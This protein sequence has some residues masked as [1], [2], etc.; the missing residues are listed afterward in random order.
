[1][2]IDNI[3]RNNTIDEWRIQTNQSA[4]ALNTI[5][6]GNF[7]KSN[8]SLTI[9]SN[10]SLVITANGTALQVSNTVLFQTRLEVGNV[11]SLGVR[12]SGTGNLTVGNTVSILGANTAL[13]VANNATVNT[14]LTVGRNIL[15]PNTGNVIFAN[16]GS[17]N[18]QT[19]YV[20]NAFIKTL[21]VDGNKVIG[22]T[23]SAPINYDTT[24]G[25][26]S[27]ALSGVTAGTYANS[28]HVPVITINSTGHVTSVSNVSITITSAA[29]SGLA[30]SATTDTTNANNIITGTLSSSVLP[31]VGTAGTYANNWHIPVITVDAYG[32]VTAITNT[33][34]G[35]TV[36]TTSNVQFRTIGVNTTADTAN[37]GSIRATGDITAFFSDER[38]KEDIVIIT[39]ALHKI[40]NIRGVH[41][42]PNDVAVTYGYKKDRKVGVIAQDIEKVLPNIVVAAPFDI[43]ENGNSKSGENYKTVQYERL[44]PLLIEAIKELSKE[45]EDLKKQINK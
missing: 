5:E 7:T 4:N 39:D 10:G 16:N 29:V 34:I 33:S 31:T 44:V 17:A 11:I 40:N 22:T 43:D 15:L 23:N 28:S 25:E 19:I 1:M 30:N 27:H 18:I 26:V 37:A 3:T 13:F 41:Y 36:T 6:T 9:N 21:N 32:R 20:T 12:E 42:T 14:S 35:Q 38:L 45:L 24:T 2:A 8:G